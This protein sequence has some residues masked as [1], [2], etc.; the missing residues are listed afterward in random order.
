MKEKE[1]KRIVVKKRLEEKN[2]KKIEEE[3]VVRKGEVL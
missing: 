2:K 3:N 1:V